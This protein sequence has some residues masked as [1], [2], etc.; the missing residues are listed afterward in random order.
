MLRKG[1]KPDEIAELCG[2]DLA[3]VQEIEASMLETV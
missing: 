2:Y 3:F 1:K